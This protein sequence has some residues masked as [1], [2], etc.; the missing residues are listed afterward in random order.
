MHRS[1][2]FLW[3]LGLALTAFF[4][5][6][7][8]EALSQESADELYEA[9]VFKKEAEGDLEGAIQIFLKVI[10]KF[11]ENRK[12]AA[13][14]QL[15]IGICYE[16]LGLNEAEKAFQKVI[17]NYPEQSEEV[18]TA[19][20]K[21]SLILKAQSVIGTG[22]K[23]LRIRQVWS[24]PDASSAGK[25]SPDGKYLSFV[26]H[27]T[28]DLAI[29]EIASG[30][31]IRV[32]SKGSWDNSYEFAVNS[33]WS[34][35]GQRLAYAW[36]N[37]DS[38]VELRI[39][40]VDGSNVRTL[41]QKKNEWAFPAAWS[42]DGK[43]IAA[44]VVRDY[45]TSYSNGLIS[46]EDGSLRILKTIKLLKTAP[47]NM[48]FSPDGR[49]VVVDYPQQEKDPMHD[50]F[51]FSVDGQQEIPVVQ[52]PA[53]DFVLDWV[54]GSDYLLFSSDR[55]GTHDAWMVEIVD[56]QPRGEPLLVR[57]DIGQIFPLGF[58]RD[59]SFYYR[60]ETEMV[61]ISIASFDLEKR[62]VVD[63]PRKIS[64]RFVGAN[65]DPVW[66]PDGKYLAFLSD[67]KAGPGG[68]TSQAL[69]IRSEETG[70][71]REVSTK[72]RRF[73]RPR[74]APDGRSIFVV[75]N[76]EKTFLALYRVDIQTGEASFFID[77]EPGAN[78]KDFALS[79]DGKS[80]FYAYFE[81]AKMQV[82]II[83]LNLDTRETKE[84]YRKEAPPDIG[85][86]T[87]SPDG[88][89]LS[90]I[91]GEQGWPWFLR[92]I[93]LA[94]GEPRDLIK[95]KTK[96]VGTYTWTP[97]G[98]RIIFF[99]DVSTKKE[100]KSELWFIPAEGGEPQSLGLTIDASPRV[101]SLHPDGRRMA[102][103]VRQPN[104][105]VWVMEN[106]LPVEKAKK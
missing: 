58:S 93:P 76:D 102:F 95:L 11:P 37:K 94:G 48:A 50:V 82:R 63:P 30:K 21:L 66:S 51:L 54:P 47:R 70:E 36:F 88:K 2:I 24:G 84:L 61:D 7:M 71:T 28:G 90:F 80:V 53:D 39:I 59:G 33:C 9:A 96:P 74:W 105:E 23:G 22:D 10:A 89:N 42:P 91:T 64:Q 31:T 86:L 56:G 78:I 57:K 41:Y 72:L 6:P 103:S 79:P 35:D 65:Y 16:K 85:G 98:K 104:A 18:K 40:G 27:S 52:H 87:V 32:T 75:G 29:R 55:T 68:Q 100:Q 20:E 69:W 62:T 60:L 26:D 14:A 15:Q 81:F 92:A 13:K 3:V 99:N 77:S 34:P 67:R 8:Q 25:P 5:V 44:Y 46:V 83:S 97:D 43:S 4:L 101:L 45:Y 1:K 73:G 106:F 19:K 49:Y 17:D 38:F 12:V